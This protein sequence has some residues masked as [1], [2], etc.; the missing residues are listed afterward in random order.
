MSAPSCGFS[1]RRPCSEAQALIPDLSKLAVSKILNIL[2]A[3]SHI[4]FNS[5]ETA[6]RQA[7]VR[8]MK[9]HTP[10]RRLLSRHNRQLLRRYQ[11]T[12]QL[13]LQIAERQVADRF[14]EL[15]PAERAV[16]TAVEDYIATTYQNAADT[17]RS[18]V[19]FVM[20]IYRRRLASSF[21]ALRR[22]L[23]K[24]RLALQGAETDLFAAEAA[25]QVTLQNAPQ[26][27]KTRH[28][29]LEGLQRDV[30]NPTLDQFRAVLDPGA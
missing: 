6:E 7:A 10:L 8:L 1:R 22:T 20:T 5:L 15:S 18:A 16:Y 12:G 28:E 27:D 17:E 29:L 21:Y 13:A 24:R 11:Q 25:A 9:A 2:R 14:V 19:G 4:A 30:E 26:R 3:K 23:E